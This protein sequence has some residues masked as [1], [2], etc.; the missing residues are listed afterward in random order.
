MNVTAAD[1]YLTKAHDRHL[2]ELMAF[3]RIASVSAL[4]AHKDA[5]A[6]AADWLAESLRAGLHSSLSRCRQ[7]AGPRRAAV[8]GSRRA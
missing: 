7:A 3:L 6:K 1:A 2:Q 4:P 5:V 8:R